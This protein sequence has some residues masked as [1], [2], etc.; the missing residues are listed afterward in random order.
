MKVLYILAIAFIFTCSCNNNEMPTPAIAED[1]TYYNKYLDTISDFT[2]RSLPLGGCTGSG[3]FVQVGIAIVAPCVNPNN[4][5]EIAFIEITANNEY[6][7]QKFSFLTGKKTLLHKGGHSFLDWSMKG[8]LIFQ[9]DDLQ[10]WKIKDNGDS[11]T[12]LTNNGQY[13]NFSKWS[14][15]GETFVYD[16]LSTGIKVCNANGTI[17]N[18]PNLPAGGQYIDWLNDSMII[19]SNSINIVSCNIKTGRI[20]TRRVNFDK[21]EMFTEPEKR[22]AHSLI[23]NISADRGYYWTKYD[24][25][26]QQTDTLRKFYDSYSCVG[27]T[28]LP[29]IKKCLALLDRRDYIDRCKIGYRWHL[30]LMNP[31]GTDEKL[32][33]IPQ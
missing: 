26:T 7:I 19:Y 8:W 9:E 31:D 25:N 21:R 14:P 4:Q 33:R 11:L 30:I 24:Y 15:N 18:T 22:Y 20:E 27:V 2:Y 28:Y 6:S 3:T 29:K 12:Q 17:V 16:L 5:Y 1:I 13:N 10:L 32:I 23:R